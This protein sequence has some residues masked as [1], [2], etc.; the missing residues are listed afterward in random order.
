M[1]N[2]SKAWLTTLICSRTWPSIGGSPVYYYFILNFITFLLTNTPVLTDCRISHPQMM[3]LWI[4]MISRIG[5]TIL[6]PFVLHTLL[7]DQLLPSSTTPC[8]AHLG[9]HFPCLPAL[10]LQCWVASSFYPFLHRS[11]FSIFF[12]PS[13]LHFQAHRWAGLSHYPSVYQGHC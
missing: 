13:L 8:P 11:V 4:W 3:I 9:F 6:T 5:W 1:P 7:N 12:C 2:T 10:S